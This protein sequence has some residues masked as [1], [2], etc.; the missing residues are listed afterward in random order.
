MFIYGP[1]YNL[2]ITFYLFMAKPLAQKPQRA[3]EPKQKKDSNDVELQWVIEQ[4]LWF[5]NYWVKIDGLD[6]MITAY[7][8]GKMK[9]RK[10]KVIVGDV[11]M[12]KINPDDRSKGIITYRW[13]T[14]S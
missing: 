6:Q 2:L 3:Y 10:I 11:V 9:M 13:S 8:W 14:R 12:V 5:G 4:D 1:R 7:V